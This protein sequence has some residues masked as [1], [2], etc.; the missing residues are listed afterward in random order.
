MEQD[1]SYE[2]SPHP[3]SPIPSSESSSPEGVRPEDDDDEA[4]IDIGPDQPATAK[5]GEG[6]REE[7]KEQERSGG[8]GGEMKTGEKTKSG[9]GRAGIFTGATGLAALRELQ[10]ELLQPHSEPTSSS[11]PL[12]TSSVAPSVAG[13]NDA[14]LPQLQSEGA[15]PSG[16]PG[17]GL[18]DVG[19]G[20][21]GAES[22]TGED[23]LFDEWSSFSQFVDGGKTEEASAPL[24]WE[25]EL[26]QVGPTS[27]P[28]LD[29]EPLS[30]AAS[31]QQPRPQEEKDPAPPDGGKPRGSEFDELFALALQAHQ[32]PG[33]GRSGESGASEKT[34][35][36]PD[37]LLAPHTT[38]GSE[39]VGVGDLSLDPLAIQAGS[40][41]TS[42]TDKQL[43]SAQRSEVTGGSASSDLQA[44]S[45]VFQQQTGPSPLLPSTLQPSPSTLQ[46][47]PVSQ[48]P[49]QQHSI[50][51]P[52]QSPMQGSHIPI[53]PPA[54]PG[55][56]P[57]SQLSSRGG[58]NGI[59]RGAR[60]Q[61]AGTGRSK[62]KEGGSSWMNV[63]ADLD[64]LNNEKV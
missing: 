51:P 8:G 34:E 60:P 57:M 16:L 49:T 22:S 29:F 41:A 9:G 23:Q 21:E 53:L 4:L 26:S 61:Q 47:S 64:P 48:L 54:K 15:E 33:T 2:A 11:P 31:A 40:P 19:E 43:P 38:G 44:L 30:S 59:G 63:F 62:V 20:G 25:K 5:E 56:V 7:G 3:T 13:S 42:A 17:A 55:L 28:L 18:V 50:L 12:A 58:G 39:G 46:P 10:S 52:F 6:E 36:G 27:D 1:E 37:P 45:S 14:N 32:P 24:D 35:S